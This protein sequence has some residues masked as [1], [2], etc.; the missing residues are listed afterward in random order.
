MGTSIGHKLGLGSLALVTVALASAPAR[1]EVSAETAFVFNTFSFLVSGF[2]VMWM[3]AGFAM[4]E[5]GLVRTKNTATIC[6]KNI[7]LYAIAGILYYIIG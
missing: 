6:L 3:A 1:A 7:A 5:A 4:L 2:L